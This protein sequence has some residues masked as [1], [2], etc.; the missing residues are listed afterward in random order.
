MVIQNLLSYQLEGTGLSSVHEASWL[1]RWPLRCALQS[2]R[3]A[4][5]GGSRYAAQLANR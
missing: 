2:P 4:T 5:G 1:L 3:A